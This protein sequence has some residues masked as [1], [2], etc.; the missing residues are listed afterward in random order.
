MRD[1]L[2]LL[3]RHSL[4]KILLR[5]LSLEVELANLLRQFPGRR[6]ELRVLL[7][8][9]VEVILRAFHRS[10]VSTS[11]FS[12]TLVQ[13]TLSGVDLLLQDA[14]LLVASEAVRA[15][16]LALQRLDLK[17]GVV[18]VFLLANHLRV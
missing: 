17:L 12:A 3:L 4:S 11:A 8:R 6:L 13:H 16:D 18:Q 10:L 1:H 5:Q 2:I 9:L 7:A 14:S 15:R